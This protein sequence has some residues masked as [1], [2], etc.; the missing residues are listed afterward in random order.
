MRQ[1]HYYKRILNK[2]IWYLLQ[3][4]PQTWRYMHDKHILDNSFQPKNSKTIVQ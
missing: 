4:M 3:K 2:Y 1:V